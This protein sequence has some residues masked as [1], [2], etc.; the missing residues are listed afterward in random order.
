MAALILLQ[1]DFCCSPMAKSAI[2]FPQY[3]MLL[4]ADFVAEVR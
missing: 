4:L 1:P 3:K 2:V